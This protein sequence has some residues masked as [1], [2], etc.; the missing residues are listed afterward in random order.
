LKNFKSHILIILLTCLSFLVAGQQFTTE[1]EYIS[2]ADGLAQNHVF[3]VNQ[4]KYGFMWFCTMGGLS[5]YDGFTFTNYYYSEEDSTTISSSFTDKFFEDSKGRYWVSTNR[6]FNRFYREAGTF[7]RY[8]HDVENDNT[9]G[10]N[11]TRGIAEDSDGKLWI[12]HGR[13][14][15]RFDPDTEIFEHFYDDKFSLLRHDGDILLTKNGDILIMGTLG[16][17]KVDKNNNNLIFIGCPDIKADIS[18]DGRELYQDSYGN[19]WAGFNRGL[20]KF[21]TE[22][23]KFEVIDFHGVVLDVSALKEYPNDLLVIGTGGKGLILYSISQDRIINNFNYSPS[24]PKGIS[25]S[26][27]YSLF[28][29]KVNNLWI[30]LFY[31]LNRINPKSQRFPLLENESGVNNLKNFTLHVYQDPLGGYWINTMEGLFYRKNLYDKYISVLHPPDFKSGYND[32]RGIE[33]NENG[34][35]LINVRS[36]GLYQFDVKKSVVTK[37]GPENLF[38]DSYIF[39][40]KT[41][42]KDTNILWLT[43][44]GGICKMD[45]TT[46]DTVWYHPSNINQSLKTD[47][48]THF[49]Q[50]ED[51][52]LFFINGGLLCFFDPKNDK[53]QVI[54]TNFRIKG[55]VHAISIRKHKVWVATTTNLYTFDLKIQ[56]WTLLKRSDGVTDLKSVGLQIDNNDVAWTIHGS[57]ITVIGPSPAKTLHYQ[58]P[59]S[60]VNGIGAKSMEGY[61]LFGGSNGA[62]LINPSKFYRDTIAPKVVFTGLEIANKPIKL[63]T[64]DEFIKNIELDYEDKVFTLKFAALH[65][66]FRNQIKYRYQLKGFDKEWMDSGTEKSVTYTN[67]RPGNYTFLVEAISE[68][69]VTS[70][71]PLEIAIYIKPPYYLTLPFFLFIALIVALLVYIYYR[72]NQKAIRLNREKELAEKNAE[73]KSMFLANM[74]H[75]I[76]TPMN[77]I[78]GLNRLLLDTPLNPKQNQYVQAVQTSS[79]NLLWIVNDILDQ[80]KIESGKYTIVHKPFDLTVVLSQLETL[81]AFRAKEKKLHFFIETVGDIPKILIGDQ[82]R[83]FQV[84][85]NL[86][87][88]AIKF[89]ETGEVRLLVNTSPSENNKS[90]ITF[91]ISDTGIGIPSDRLESIFES[92][93]QVNEYQSVGTQGTGLGLS[94]VKN[95]VEQ[96]GSNITVVSEH[97]KGSTFAFTLLFDIGQSTASITNDRENIKLPDGLRVLLVEDTPFNQLLAIELLKKHIT[98][99]ETDVAENGQIAIEKIMENTYDLVLMDVKMPVMNGIEAT[100]KIRSMDGE[101]FKKLPIAGLTA[102]A[103][104]QQI[105]LCIESGMD[106]CITKPINADE[107]V[108]KISKLIDR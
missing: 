104:P 23:L 100:K 32:V 16:I 36:N 12:V 90:Q 57:E 13:G 84:L 88:N 8:L 103:T 42:F 44:S 67:L 64:E 68:D 78:I 28:V 15:D 76:R 11:S 31:G 80:A 62:I 14:V 6:G 65:F 55:S 24:D 37:L 98:N 108:Y 97:G 56:T 1:F 73:Y 89:T 38:K 46:F 30:G 107:L 29:D 18:L 63:G 69:G 61:L 105:A 74:S 49:E 41:D 59:T 101:Y 7:K 71:V 53:I 92:F 87:G 40:I 27:V 48:V 83:L 81:F 22:T 33:G 91:K 21:N 58:S 72:I 86:L 47:N 20:A 45:K 93:D 54:D 34:K 26:A 75:E 85:T 25:G 2:S 19:V 39:K 5:K 4:D 99:V 10:H 102:N 106:E 95:L 3:S 51:G 66:L 70:E 60:F 94:I 77:A 50:V 17:F 43:G 9:L 35:V 82:V 96:L 52:R 79:E